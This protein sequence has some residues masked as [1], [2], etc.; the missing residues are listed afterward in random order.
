MPKVFLIK[1]RLLQ[2]QLRLLESQNAA[3][4]KNE[5]LGDSSS[6]QPLSLIVQKK[7][8]KSEHRER[9]TSS[10][11]LEESAKKESVPPRRFISSILGGDV[12]YGSRGHVLTRAERK[13]Y[14]PIV[15][16]DK[17]SL[18][19]TQKPPENVPTAPQNLAPVRCSVIQR[20]PKPTSK[21][22]EDADVR[23][24]SVPVVQE[25][26]QEQPIDY[27]IPKRRG[28]T[29]DE[30]EERRDR[31]QR[32]SNC[33]KISKPL[34]SGR[35]IVGK[36]P[37]TISAAAGHGRGSSGAQGNTNQTT[38]NT[39]SSGG[40]INFTSSS[41]GGAGGALGGGT[42]GGGM[43]PGRDGRQNYG[44]SSPPTG[45]LPPFYESLKGGNNNNNYNANSN[46]GYNIINGHQNMDT[47]Q[48]INL[49]LNGN[50][51]PPKQYS[52]LQNASYGLVMKDEVDLDIYETKIDPMGNLLPNSYSGYDESMM[53]DMVTGAVV[54]P[55]QFT[56]TLT[57]SSSAEHALLE[58]LSDAA[59]LSTFLQRLPSDENEKGILHSP[60][61]TPDSSQIQNVDNMD[62]FSDHLLNRSYTN[63]ERFNQHNQFPKMYQ[64]NLPS[65]PVNNDSMVQM[66]QQQQMLSPSLSFN[67]SGLDLDSPTTMSLPSPGAA[68][69]S[70]DGGSHNDNGSLSPPANV[71]ARRNSSSNDSPGRVNVMQ[72]RLG[73]SS[74]VQLEFVN[75]GHGIKNPLASQDT[76][77]TTSRTEEKPKV[78]SITTEDGQSHFCCRICNKT[79][80]LQRLLNRHMKC[81]SDVKRYLCTFCGKGFNDTFD[82]K[83]HT[84]THTGVRPY[85]C[86]LCEKSFTQRCSLESH[87]LKVHGVQHQYAYKERRTKV[88]V[89]EECGHTTS[90]PEVHYIHLKEKHPY[91][92]ALLKFYDKRHFKFTNSNFAN[93]LLQ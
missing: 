26:E 53:V 75:G 40:S 23:L 78:A 16:P 43:N 39:S 29:E 68:S 91:S 86:S 19:V 57:F 5:L 31:E 80:A 25:P 24:P 64:D 41:G 38:S 48:E 63:N 79:F 20:T 74:D 44:P 69:C 2:Q 88:Y 89:C 1:E 27:H 11:Q 84:R 9:A 6:A 93:M 58:S 7:D 50:Q 52:T 60:S 34:I 28:E 4:T 65:Y 55:M 67:G 42:G 90:E 10:P 51:S 73:L 85:K 66:Q 3:A 35:A 72:R 70:L 92:P 15:P 37:T 32:R 61:I 77:R 36:L 71:S 8:E 47:G 21:R 83:R 54:D 13:E 17:Q 59:D 46:F 76:I 62:Q 81:H 22:E 82:L 18:P 12:P 33:H 30:N 49:N 87:C 45:S 56:A 14:A